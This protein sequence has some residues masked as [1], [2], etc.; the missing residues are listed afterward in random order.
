MLNWGG[1]KLRNCSLLC[2]ND[3]SRCYESEL[4]PKFSDF[5]LLSKVLV[6][7]TRSMI[8]N[9]AVLLPCVH[10][11][12]TYNKLKAVRR[13]WNNCDYSLSLHRLQASLPTSLSLLED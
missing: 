3:T 1:K 8:N 6:G 9:Y 13:T 11:E 7:H 4:P 12:V 10:R 2:S 5:T